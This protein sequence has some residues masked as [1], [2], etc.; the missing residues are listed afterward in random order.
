M[1]IISKGLLLSWSPEN[2]SGRMAIE[3]PEITLSHTT[4]YRRIAKNKEKGG[5]R[6]AGRLLIPERIDIS[7][8]PDI[9]EHR[10]RIGDW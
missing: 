6:Q 5:K 10:Q 7:E 1:E 4:I 3:L 2:I 8:R 9:V